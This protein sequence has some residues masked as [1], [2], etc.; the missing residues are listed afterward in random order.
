MVKVPANPEYDKSFLACR[1]LPFHC[2]LTWPLLGAFSW[3][4][5]GRREHFLMSL[6]IRTPILLDQ[7]SNL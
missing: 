5:V 6:L 1:Q 7:G 3:G 4:W 2:V